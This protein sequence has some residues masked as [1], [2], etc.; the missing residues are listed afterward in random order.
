MRGSGTALVLACFWFC[1]GACGYRM[2]GVPCD[3]GAGVRSVAVPLFQNRSFEPLAEDVFTETFRQGVESRPCVTLGS[4]GDAE[5]LLRGTV[6]GVEVYP[7][8]VDPDFLVL[9]YGMRVSLC[10]SLTSRDSGEVLWESGPMQEEVRFYAS[11]V[12][13]V[14]AD[15]MLLQANRREALTQLARTMARRSLERLLLGH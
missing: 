15:P 3:A 8:A 6:L 1:L 2:G 10:L 9:E 7:V 11:R 4:A 5:A 12:P 14:P 13:A